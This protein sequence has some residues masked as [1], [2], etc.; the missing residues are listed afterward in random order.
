MRNYVLLA[1]LVLAGIVPFAS[2][3]VYMDEHIFL[4]VARSAQTN[5]FFPQDTPWIFFGTRSPNLAAHTHPPV[6]E[7][8]LAVLYR[9]FGGFREIPFRI[10]FSIFPI[11]AV[12]AFYNLARRFT[13]HPF[14]VALIFAANA[15]FFVYIPTLMMDIPMLAF[16]LVGFALYFGHVQGRRG[17]LP[18]AAASFALAVGAGYTALVPLACLGLVQIT[19]RRPLKELLALCTA[20]AA[21]AL[22]LLAMTI[23]FGEFPLIRTVSYYATQGSV[24]RN[25]LAILSF[26]GG[27]TFFF[28]LTLGDWRIM[29]A[30]IPIVTGLT[31]FASWPSFAYRA[32]FIVLASAGLVVLVAFLSHARRLVAAGKNHGEAFLIL[33]VPGVL[34]FFTVVADMIN[35][36]YILLIMPALCLV[37]F[38]NAGERRLILTL[39]PTAVLS[40][41]LAYADFRFVNLNRDLVKQ[42]VVPL[43]QEGFHV[44]SAAES[45][46]RFYLEQ[47]G[48]VTLSNQDVTPGPGDLVVRHRG[49]FGYSLAEP[50][51]TNLIVLKTFPLNVEFPVRIYSA[52]AGAGFHDSGAGLVPF[53]FSRL[54]YDAVEVAQVSPLLHAAVW[55]RDGPVFIQHEPERE[56]SIK[57]PSDARIEFER[58][59]EGVVA[60]YGDHIQLKKGNSPAIVWRNFRIVPKHW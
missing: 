5:W 28:A 27:V 29:A 4:H 8:Y 60:I 15:S 49:L 40:I 31:L 30:S 20:P 9:A 17:F 51:S 13:P 1:A 44:W 59:G 12:L 22:W 32:W 23:H 38:G 54:S 41:T 45:G 16:L 24:F 18:L 6:G 55:S 35:A 50:L 26:L 10:A 56:F 19:T 21:L 33:W 47:Q 48:I 58:D 3:A 36:R 7:Y 57:I 14:L 34:L 53:T 37:L 11:A 52:P 39:I 42:I 46:L 2:R 25:I 43:Q